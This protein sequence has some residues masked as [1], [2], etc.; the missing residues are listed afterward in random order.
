LTALVVYKQ[1]RLRLQDGDMT[2][3]FDRDGGRDEGKPTP[4]TR[5]SAETVKQ[6]IDETR[7]FISGRAVPDFTASVMQQIEQQDLRPVKPTAWGLFSRAAVSLW[8][9]RDVSLTVRPAYALAAAAA[10]V[11]FVA[12]A[13]SRQ[14]ASVAPATAV[15]LEPQLFV[16]FRLEARDAS[17]VRI[18]GSFTGW[19]PSHQLHQ[20]APGLWTVTLPL[21]RGVHDYAFLVDGT[22]WVADPFAQQVNDGFGGINSRIALLAPDVP[23]T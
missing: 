1:A 20:A 18:A 12:Y 21:P 14:P 5:A 4:E 2:D 11:L 19:K 17:D 9:A 6:A 22:E 10:V 7:A 13:P 23:L 8:A 3:E 16:Q 15:A